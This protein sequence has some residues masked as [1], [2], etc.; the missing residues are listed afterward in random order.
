MQVA[1]EVQKSRQVLRE[2]ERRQATYEAAGIRCVWLVESV[3]AGYQATEQLPMFKV[4]DWLSSPRAVV[5]GRSIAL[6]KLV[7]HLLAGSCRWRTEIPSRGGI[8]EL[9]SLLCPVCGTM[10]EAQVA[11]WMRG[12]C[13][14]GL[15]VSRQVRVSGD[16]D[17]RACCGYWGPALSIRRRT[18]RRQSDEPVQVGHWCLTA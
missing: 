15:P 3:P 10:R 17:R 13:E 18:Y 4:E 16:V 6:S 5:A 14:C 11:Q 1:F 7:A 12:Q 2:Y 8:V 9:V